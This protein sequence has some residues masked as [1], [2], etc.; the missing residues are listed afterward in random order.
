MFLIGACATIP[1]AL[2][3]ALAWSPTVLI[4][5]RILSGLAGAALIP[6][7]LSL[8]TAIWPAGSG[9]TRAIA[10]WSGPGGGHGCA[11][12]D[13]CRVTHPV[14]VVELGI[15]TPDPARLD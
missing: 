9:R 5:G 4:I 15:H 11:R 12:P 13:V 3:C 7:T 14:A 10:L 2:L 1:T 6:T 8:I